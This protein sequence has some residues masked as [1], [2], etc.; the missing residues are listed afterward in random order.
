MIYFNCWKSSGFDHSRS[1]YWNQYRDRFS[2]ALICES[3]YEFRV[4]KDKKKERIVVRR[5]S[6][7]LLGWLGE[8]TT[9]RVNVRKSKKSRRWCLTGWGF[10]LQAGNIYKSQVGLK[11]K[12]V[13]I[14]SETI[15][16]LWGQA[17]RVSL[18]VIHCS[19]FASRAIPTWY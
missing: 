7:A 13:R 16:N 4:F 17:M 14:R 8:E 2:I 5:I 15:G 18:P 11:F 19:L 3:R 12:L 9:Q 10:I 1:R 6:R